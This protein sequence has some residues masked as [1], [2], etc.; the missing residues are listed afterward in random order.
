[1]D[2]AVSIVRRIL[3]VACAAAALYAPPGIAQQAQQRIT[4]EASLIN[5][6]YSSTFGTGLYK[7][8]PAVAT[9]IRFPISYRV[10]EMQGEQWGVNL[11]APLTVGVYHLNLHE[12]NQIDLNQDVGAGSLVPGVEVEIQMSERWR[13]KPYAQLGG[14]WE[15]GNPPREA[16]VYSTGVKSLYRFPG[17]DYRVSLGNALFAAGYRVRGG[18]EEQNIGVFQIGVNTE[19]PWTV[20]LWNG[21][22]HF[23]VHAIVTRY[24]S[25]F[26][27]ADPEP[28]KLVVRDEYQVGFSFARAKP[29]TFMGFGVDAI[30]VGFRFANNVRGVSLYTEFPF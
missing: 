23:N 7:V 10:R 11:I 28:G 8:G 27:F 19:T 5:W 26:A 17:T 3:I 15:A 20:P 30:G 2:V 1:M 13:L 4:S 14:G 12:L 6:W 18:S 22:T 16:W 9:V 29:W 21:E 24:W 25:R